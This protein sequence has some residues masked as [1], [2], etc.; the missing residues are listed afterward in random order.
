MPN[1]FVDAYP[2]KAPG[3]ASRHR[4]LVCLTASRLR[5]AGVVA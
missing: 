5:E 3:I 4:G 2:H 1:S